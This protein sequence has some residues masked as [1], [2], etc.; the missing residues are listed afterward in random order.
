[1]D[2]VHERPRLVVAAA[3]SWRVGLTVVLVT[4]AVLSI[5]ASRVLQSAKA[6]YQDWRVRWLW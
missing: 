2:R 6:T 5:T 1:M 3:V 4:W